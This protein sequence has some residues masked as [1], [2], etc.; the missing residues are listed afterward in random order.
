MNGV[1]EVSRVLI[2]KP[3]Q[4]THFKKIL[5]IWEIN[6]KYIAKMYGHAKLLRN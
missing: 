5:I 3:P 2:G 4:D 6:G 1:Q